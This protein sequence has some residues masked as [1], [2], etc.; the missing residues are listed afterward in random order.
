MVREQG[1]YVG[2]RTLT[3]ELARQRRLYEGLRGSSGAWLATVLGAVIGRGLPGLADQHPGVQAFARA[4]MRWRELDPTRHSLSRSKGT[5]A[6]LVIRDQL[7][8]PVEAFTPKKLKAMQADDG[9]AAIYAEELKAG[10][11]A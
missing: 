4:I 9:F 6:G 5:F 11:L 1:L 10:G 8:R 2:E 3:A 7:G